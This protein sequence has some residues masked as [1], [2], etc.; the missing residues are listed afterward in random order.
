MPLRLR[1]TAC[2][3]EYA[4]TTPRELQVIRRALQAR[5][6]PNCGAEVTD[7]RV[8]VTENS[9]RV[10]TRSSTQVQGWSQ[11]RVGATSPPA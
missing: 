9:P 11:Q 6:C 7:Y 4:A 3:F 10:G 5:R 1:C 2:G 8:Y